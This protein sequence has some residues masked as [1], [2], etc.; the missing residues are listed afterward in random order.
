[1]DASLLD[2]TQVK[3]ITPL[4]IK[5]IPTQPN[6][7]TGVTDSLPPTLYEKGN[8]AITVLSMPTPRKKN[9]K[10]KGKSGA[11]PTTPENGGKRQYRKFSPTTKKL[12]EPLIEA[13]D[14]VN[15]LL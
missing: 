4:S 6:C 1:V 13:V 14:K 11:P 15:E 10:R 7:N 3:I 9:R 2:V 8:D 12:R 5:S